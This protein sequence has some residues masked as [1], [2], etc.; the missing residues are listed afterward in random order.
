MS[1]G[2]YAV[3]VLVAVAVV[4]V[5][6]PVALPQ[7]RP[8]RRPYLDRS[9]DR[10]VGR[11][12]GSSTRALHRLF[13]R[14]RGRRHRVPQAG[15]VASWCD[16]LSRR[17][18]A[19]STLRDA[20]MSTTSDSL[21]LSV[22]LAGVRLRLERGSTV[23]EALADVAD[24]RHFALATSVVATASQ[25]GGPSALALDRAAASLRLRAA[26][27]QERAAHSAQARMSA[28]V[29]TFVPL[30]FLA[31]MLTVDE[32]V[33]SVVASRVGALVAVVGLALNGLGWIWMRSVI[34]RAT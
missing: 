21:P 23:E 34:G 33:R 25:V 14:L 2:A 16:D 20:L 26:D 6:G 11:V 13:A 22:A 18:R 12:T 8:V 15:D 9:R 1:A 19:G 29:L 17:V 30:A 24:D 32:G 4:A 27:Q 5:L 3:P 31:L 10:L 7:R 28:H